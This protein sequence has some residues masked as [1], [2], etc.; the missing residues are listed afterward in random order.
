MWRYDS[1]ADREAKRAALYADQEW[2]AFIP[3]TRAF[4][5]KMQNRILVPTS[6]SPLQ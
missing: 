4:I 6:F 5:E 3:K 1:H 2:L